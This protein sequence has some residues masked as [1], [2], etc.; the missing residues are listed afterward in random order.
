MRKIEVNKALQK[1]NEDLQ[2]D[3]SDLKQTTHNSP[4]TYS[5]KPRIIT[6]SSTDLYRTPE[7]LC[8]IFGSF[9][10]EHEDMQHTMERQERLPGHERAMTENL[11]SASRFREWMVSTIS[12]ELLVQGDFT[13]DRQ[14]SALSVFA[15]TLTTALRARPNY[16]SLVHFCGLHTDFNYDA[17]AGPRGMIMSFIAQL[18]SQWDFDMEFLHE[19]VDLSWDEYGEDP[20]LEDIS[21]L[22]TWLVRQ[23]PLGQTVF[24]ITDGVHHYEKAE[25]VDVLIGA[26]GCFL[27]STLDEHVGATVKILVTSP[28]RT[29]EVREAFHDNAMLLLGDQSG[30]DLEASP[31]RFQ[32]QVSRMLPT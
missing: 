15:S 16:I 1:K 13:G 32:Y 19:S 9:S 30:R 7:E 26:M 8:D 21:D 10:F 25:Y 31:R 6:N 3:I 14:I 29:V 11:I 2:R 22:L 5:P 17:D 24:Y 28:C 4:W 12:R 20:S 27:D 18:L 23:L